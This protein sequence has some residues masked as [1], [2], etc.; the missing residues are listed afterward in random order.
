M[1]ALKDWQELAEGLKE[2]AKPHKTDDPIERQWY[3][4]AV[5]RAE[6]LESTIKV[7]REYVEKEMAQARAAL[8][9]GRQNEA[10]M[11]H[12][13][14]VEQFSKYTDLADLFAPMERERFRFERHDPGAQNAEAHRPRR[15]QR[16]AKSSTRQTESPTTGSSP[17]PDSQPSPVPKDVPPES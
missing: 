1:T 9:A 3:L 17:T 5:K 11:I 13:Q 14:L 7:R 15:R 10:N 16:I 12:G 8:R 2:A 6:Q 4:L